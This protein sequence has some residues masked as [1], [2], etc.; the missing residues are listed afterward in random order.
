MKVKRRNE[1]AEEYSKKSADEQ[2]KIVKAY[3]FRNIITTFIF[4]YIVV[5]V[6]V[7][8]S[9]VLLTYLDEKLTEF[10]FIQHRLRC[11]I[12]IFVLSAAFTI[13]QLVIHFLS[14]RQP[15][16][17]FVRATQKVVNG[18]YTARINT[19]KLSA[20]QI[21]F[22]VIG[23]NFNKMV[24]QLNE[25]ESISND[26]ISNV[27]HEFK[28]PLAV[29][30]SYAT[31]LQNPVLSEN[32][33][34]ECVSKIILSTKQLT[35]LIT[36]IL[37]LNKIENDQMQIKK[38]SFNLSSELSQCLID[39][40]EKWEEK[41][42]NIEFE[43]E[44]DIMYTS[45]KDMLNLVWTNLLSNAIKFTP[46]NGTIGIYLSTYPDKLVVKISDTGCGISEET[47]SHIFEKF[48]QGDTS[49][50]EKGNGLGLCLAK[51]VL[52]T[53]SNEIEVQDN[54]KGGTCFVVTLHK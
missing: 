43:V 22:F 19:K 13:I 42:L 20:R 47:K 35:E 5:G 44:D 46:E 1:L 48:Y 3:Y 37:R 17:D 32:E 49:H 23:E 51:R 36:N 11:A 8:T 54:P 14:I 34:N 53:T 9:I 52:D 27:S 26:F 45:D 39:F 33:K 50:S 38:A 30:Q 41:N 31:I 2:G 25:V 10:I 12:A 28:T 24:Q 6:A 7:L 16:L 29:I 18:D 4:M 40:E 15:M 21:E